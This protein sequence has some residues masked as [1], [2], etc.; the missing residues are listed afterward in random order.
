MNEQTPA[1]VFRDVWKSYPSYNHITGGIKSFLFHLPKAI[2]ELRQR[3]T[4]LEGI[5]FEIPRGTKFG[6]VG[7]NGAGKST[8]LG[9]IAGVLSPDQGQIQVNGR[10]SPLLELGAGFHPEMTGRENIMLNGVLLGLTK[11]EVLEYQDKIIEFSEL[12]EFIEQPVRTYS[13]GMYAKLGFAVVSILK[14]DI[15]LLDEILSVGD[16]A[17]KRKCDAKFE[18]FLSDRNVTIVLV[19]H[20][21]ESVSQVCEQAAW[22]EN[23]Q[24]RMVGPAADVVKEYRN[25][26][27]PKVVVEETI[28]KLSEKNTIDEG[29]E[30]VPPCVRDSKDYGNEKIVYLLRHGYSD[31]NRLRL[32]NGTPE[33]RLTPEGRL[34]AQQAANLVSQYELKFSDYYV[35]NWMRAQ[36]TA[37][38]FLP[39]QNFIVDPRLGETNSGVAAKMTFPEFKKKYPDFRFPLDMKQPFPGG[40][41]HQQ[42]YERTVEWFEECT[43]KLPRGASLLAVTHVGPISCILQHVCKMGMEGFPVFIPRHTSLTK[44]VLVPEVGWRI[45][46]FSLFYPADK[47]IPS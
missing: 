20:A 25:S 3:R 28:E 6:F 21:L 10:V 47:N 4:A 39:E 26:V 31:A 2:Q 43:N 18:E 45:E 34:Q 19:S 35:S 9:L 13:S 32:I 30:H 44:L 42:L 37:E 27:N 15:L 36:E 33:D 14:P 41:S 17:F 11:A 22:I 24:V 1:I 40:E 8:T 38:L 16:E 7:R 46:F 12:G 23:K 5:N 29:K